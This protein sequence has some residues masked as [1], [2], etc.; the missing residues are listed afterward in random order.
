MNLQDIQ[1]SMILLV[2]DNVETLGALQEYLRHSGFHVALVNNGFDAIEFTRTHHPDVVVLDVLM[3]KM[4]GFET[5]RR[6]KQDDDTK[7]IPVI[8][9]SAYDETIDKVRGFDVGGVDY[10]AKPFQHQEVVARISAHIRLR[11]LQKN[12]QEKNAQLQDEI[13]QRIHTE[14]AL[15]QSQEEFRTIFEHAPVMIASYDGNA[16]FQLWNTECEKRLKYTQDEINASDAPLSLLLP[17]AGTRATFVDGMG[18]MDGTFREY[19]VIRKDGEACVQLWAHFSLPTGQIISVGHDIT[20][21]KLAEEALLE[22]QQYSRNIIDSSLDMIIT[23]DTERRIV[24]FN[25]AAETAFGYTQEDVVGRNVN[26]LYARSEESSGVHETMVRENQS[27]KEVYNRRKNGE[28][29]PCLLSASTLRDAQGKTIGYMGISRD[30]TDLKQAQQ[31]LQEKNEQLSELNASKDK[32]FSIIS[33]DL[34]NQFGTLLGFGELV[35]EN[36]EHYDRQKIYSL[37]GKMFNSAEKLYALLENLLTWSRIQRGVMKCTPS[38]LDAGR[39]ALDNVELFQSQAERKQITLRSVVQEDQ[40]IYADYSMVDTVIRNL[41]SNALKF[42]TAGGKIIISCME[43]D[44]DFRTMSVC[45][46]GVGIPE[47]ALPNLLRIDA[48]HTTPGTSGERGTGLGLILCR[49]LIEKNGG[50]IWVNSKVG[51]GTTFSFTLPKKGP[52]A[53]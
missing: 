39:I 50:K 8:F 42:T 16:T 24:E 45:D 49:E 33:H 18:K 44:K 28:V 26:I 36:F 12:L 23:V 19:H 31:Q 51:K 43:H 29:F 20:Q 13:T 30:I 9:V 34:K 32:F 5:C 17:D 46:T 52:D 38:H 27:V 2:D 41:I 53:P 10:I 6:L 25:P 37:V 35:L 21:R 1:D 40:F 15:R 11:N 14:Q 47:D 22:S 3:P 48:H 7:N 4:D